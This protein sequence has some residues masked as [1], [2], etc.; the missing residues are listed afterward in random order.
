MQV[1]DPRQRPSKKKNNRVAKKLPLI[2]LI[3]V[4]IGAGWFAYNNKSPK[5]TAKPA[6]TNQTS[7]SVPADKQKTGKMKTYTGQQFMELY[8]SF[9]Y[10]N[11]QKISE[12]TI[13]TGNSKADQ[14]IRT[15]AVER[16]YKLQSAPVTNAFQKV[17][18][19]FTLQ[20]RAAKDWLVLKK[21][22]ATEGINIGLTAGYRSAAEQREILMERLKAAGLTPA[23]VATGKFNPQVNALLAVTAVPGYSRHHHGYTVDISCENQPAAEFVKTVCFRWLSRENY[24]NSKQYGWIPSYPEGSG[25]QGPDPEA[26]EYVWVGKDALT[27]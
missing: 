25:K 3:V 24:Q 26:W 20:H 5:Q 15:I 13:I 23:G 27:E 9:A 10:P 22:A 1:F 14:I 19:G 2:L 4:L 18:G 11:T 17:D 21:A 16:G 12:T 8:N 6:V 7:N